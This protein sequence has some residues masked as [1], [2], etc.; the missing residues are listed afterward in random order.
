VG[1]LTEPIEFGRLVGQAEYNVVLARAYRELQ[2]DWLTPVEI[3]RPWFGAALAQYMLEFR[4]HK[5][6]SDEPLSIVEVGGGTGTL[7]ASVL[8]SE[9]IQ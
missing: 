1:R 2:V 7:A 6:R 5:L 4:R 9:G 8:V 3:F